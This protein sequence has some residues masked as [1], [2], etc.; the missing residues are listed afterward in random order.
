MRSAARRLRQ[1]ASMLLPSL[2]ATTAASSLASASLE[3]A[4]WACWGPCA[5]PRSELDLLAHDSQ[6]QVEAARH[7]RA[8]IARTRVCRRCG[9]H[10]ARRC[11]RRRRCLPPLP[12]SPPLP[13]AAA[14]ATT[15]SATPASAAG[16]SWGWLQWRRQRLTSPRTWTSLWPPHSSGE[17]SIGQA[18]AASG[19]Q[20][21]GSQQQGCRV[22]SRHHTNCLPPAV[23]R[24]PTS[25]AG[26]RHRELPD[27]LA[28]RQRC[29]QPGGGRPG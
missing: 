11:R 9:A 6:A 28:Q 10:R 19:L 15:A 2:P 24:R 25:Q 7:E 23:S 16:R 26:C 18:G 4:F 13:A 27:R 3:A 12:P 22:A 21:E 5:L 17:L 1:P 20:A 8:L 29:G 14:A